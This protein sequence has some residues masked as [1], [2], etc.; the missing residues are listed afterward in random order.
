MK[1]S[2][3]LC[4]ESKWTKY[5]WAR[6]AEG[7]RVNPCDAS[8]ARWSLGG[9]AERCYGH[10]HVLLH[11]KLRVLNSQTIYD[12]I[13]YWNDADGRTFDDV[14]NLVLKLGL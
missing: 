12:S 2:E 9:A 3:L 6:T 7:V 1:I 8:A 5:T 10:D 4:D 11:E 14:K 13:E